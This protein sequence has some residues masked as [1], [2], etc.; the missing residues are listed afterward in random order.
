M[1]S[2]RLLSLGATALLFVSCQSSV[3]P[4]GFLGKDDARLAKNPAVPFS[5]SWKNP[6]ADLGKYKVI[7]VTPMKTDRLRNL[8]GLA[9]RSERNFRGVAK[10]DAVKV[11]SYANEAFAKTLNASDG[12][13]SAVTVK[14]P[15]SKGTMYLETNLADLVPGKPAAQIAK[16]FFPLAG[17]LNRPSIGVE[18][19]LVDAATGETLFAFSDYEKAEISFFDLRKFSYYGVQERE[20]QRWSK[21]LTRLIKT[22]ANSPMSDAFLIQPLAW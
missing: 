16:I 18:G 13:E 21:Q 8:S 1:K 5:R 6:E 14:A 22:N 4:T 12:R 19:R 7:A 15:K 20:I 17:L 10:K 2:L 9:A 11:A 3:Q